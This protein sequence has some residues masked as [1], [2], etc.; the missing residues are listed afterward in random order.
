MTVSVLRPSMSILSMPTFSSAPI[1][2]CVMMDSSPSAAA[3]APLVGAVH[4]GTYSASGP[5][6][7]PTPLEAEVHVDV[8]HGHALGIEE[9]LEQEIEP[10]RADV[11]DAQRVRHDRP[12]R[13]AAP[14][15][16]RDPA[17]PRGRDEVLH[18]EE[19]ARVPG[20]VDD[21]E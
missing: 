1:S 13:G 17:L 6:A 3:P 4:T 16:H 2:Y 19:V 8:G 10:E 14:R 5:G 11:R 12:R 15:A 20:R 9:P 21:A 7:I 18:D